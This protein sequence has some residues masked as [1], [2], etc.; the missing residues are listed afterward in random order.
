MFSNPAAPQQVGFYDTPGWAVGV[1]V[2]GTYAYVADYNAGLLILRNDLVSDI[3]ESASERPVKF[4]LLQNYPN[5]F[6]PVTHIRF[7]LPEAGQV[8][9]KI[10]NV[11][12]Q[13]VAELIDGYRKAGQHE[14]AFDATGLA[15]G[16][17]IYRI[18][19]G[20]KIEQKK[21]LL[22]R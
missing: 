1:A 19:A 21:M 3:A 4:E 16:I 8:S 18:Q 14:V 12:G 7:D 2:S 15:S 6:N 20:E 11:T 10:Y 13:M 17:Y 22:V 9:L 5:P